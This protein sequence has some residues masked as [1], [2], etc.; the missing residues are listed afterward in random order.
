MRSNVLIIDGDI[1]YAGYSKNALKTERAEM[2]T[3]KRHNLPVTP[4][5][6]NDISY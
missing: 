4:F 2:L 1:D 6:V 5:P 3:E